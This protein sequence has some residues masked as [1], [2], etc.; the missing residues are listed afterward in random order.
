MAAETA[1]D[2]GSEEEAEEVYGDSI[3]E[4]SQRV[5]RSLSSSSSGPRKPDPYTLDATVFGPKP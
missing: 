4:D 3:D 1:E 5:K 2:S